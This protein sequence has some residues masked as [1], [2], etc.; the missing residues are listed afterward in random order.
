M[1]KQNIIYSTIVS[2]LVGFSFLLIIQQTILATPIV[3]LSL[4]LCPFI[5]AI[6]TVLDENK[7]LKDF[8]RY[9]L[10]SISLIVLMIFFSFLNGSEI[11]GI[12]VCFSIFFTFLI[13]FIVKWNNLSTSVL[14]FFFYISV[15]RFIYLCFFKGIPPEEL[16]ENA[17]GGFISS[18]LIAYAMFIQGLDYSNNRKL[19]FVMPLFVLALSIYGLSRSGLLC[20]FL[21]LSIILAVTFES[22]NKWFKGLFLLILIAFVIYSIPYVMEFYE[23]SEMVTKFENKGMDLD[24]RDEFWRW[25]FSNIDL[26]TFVTGVDYHSYLNTM[27][28]NDNIHNSYI[29]LHG[30]LGLMGIFLMIYILKRIKYFVKRDVIMAFLFI[31]L[32]VRGFTDTI[33]FFTYLDFAVF[34]YVLEARISN[35]SLPARLSFF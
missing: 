15:F 3:A 22:L 19:D 30:T 21:Y 8:V 13:C 11:P 17:S 26:M 20:S 23:Y 24:Y 33:Y 25:Y 14:K 29:K 35:K 18:V 27:G 5:G 34:Y 1:T 6:I 28:F 31:I 4:L 7:S 10:F 12:T 16:F 2:T 32:L 9:I